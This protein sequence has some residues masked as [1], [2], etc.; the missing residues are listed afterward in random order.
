MASRLCG[1]PRLYAPPGNFSLT[2]A[3]RSDIHPSS[4]TRASAR[5]TLLCQRYTHVGTPLNV[6]R[7]TKA[8]P[9]TLDR[10][11]LRDNYYYCC[12]RY[13][14]LPSRTRVHPCWTYTR[15]HAHLDQRRNA[16]TENNASPR[17][18]IIEYLRNNRERQPFA[19]VINDRRFFN[20]L[21][22]FDD[23]IRHGDVAES[24]VMTAISVMRGT[25]LQFDI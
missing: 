17:I 7:R 22:A 11:V 23:Y 2:P 5:P 3:N 25:L 9:D 21:S 15:L 12:Y 8:R 14:I 16:G 18:P 20:Q 24:C 6:Q 19:R 1:C 13:R 4:R 10:K